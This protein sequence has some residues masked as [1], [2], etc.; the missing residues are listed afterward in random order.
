[1]IDVC[2]GSFYLTF[3]FVIVLKDILMFYSIRLSQSNYEHLMMLMIIF[4]V[5][6]LMTLPFAMMMTN[7]VC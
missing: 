3:L 2:I 5:I 6:V 1:M 4:D 7:G